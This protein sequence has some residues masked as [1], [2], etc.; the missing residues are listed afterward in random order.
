MGLIWFVSSD[1]N[2]MT[3]GGLLEGMGAYFFFL[4]RREAALSS[5]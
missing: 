4:D 3:F 5:E 1:M 2:L